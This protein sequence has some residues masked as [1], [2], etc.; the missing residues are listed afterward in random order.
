MATKLDILGKIIRD[1]SGIQDVNP[2]VDIHLGKILAASLPFSEFYTIYSHLNTEGEENE[3]DLELIKVELKKHAKRILE[4]FE[5]DSEA[6][7]IPKS[8]VD[9]VEKVLKAV[10]E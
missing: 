5:K 2:A 10:L 1:L 3:T 6:G 8:L 7:K 4:K 9:D